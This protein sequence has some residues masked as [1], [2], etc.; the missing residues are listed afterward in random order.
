MS[1]KG[2]ASVFGLCLTILTACGNVQPVS[3]VISSVPF[4]PTI[5]HW[6]ARGCR[7]EHDTLYLPWGHI[8]A[9]PGFPPRAQ[10]DF[11]VLHYETGDVI[12]GKPSYQTPQCPDFA[13]CRRATFILNPAWNQCSPIGHLYEVETLDGHPVLES[14]LLWVTDT[15]TQ[16]RVFIAFACG[17]GIA[18][19]DLASVVSQAQQSGCLAAPSRI[20]ASS[21][22]PSGSMSQDHP[23]LNAAVSVIGIALVAAAEVGVAYFTYRTMAALSRQPA[24]IAPPY[25]GARVSAPGPLPLNPHLAR[26]T[27]TCTTLQTGAVWN[28]TCF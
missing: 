11:I 10:P 7:G 27:V 19:P 16:S 26:P 28:T 25:A 15:S 18:G 9:Y 2:V 21:A 24:G 5:E 8:N 3:P 23:Y 20:Q 14:S 6:A 22:L 17:R 12:W 1:A 4:Q 13:T